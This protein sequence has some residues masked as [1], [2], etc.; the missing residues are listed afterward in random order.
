M[1]SIAPTPVRPCAA[2]TLASSSSSETYQPFH[3]QTPSMSGRSRQERSLGAFTSAVPRTRRLRIGSSS[4]IAGPWAQSTGSCTTGCKRTGLSSCGWTGRSCCRHEP[5]PSSAT[6]T[7]WW[8]L[9]GAANMVA[10]LT[11][12]PAQPLSHSQLEAK[13]GAGGSTEERSACAILRVNPWLAYGCGEGARLWL[14]KPGAAESTACTVQ[15]ILRDD[16]VRRQFG[17]HLLHSH[18][19]GSGAPTTAILRA[20]TSTIPPLAS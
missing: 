2:S 12:L 8:C 4:R 15:R 6:I 18:Q 5:V 1:A 9:R 11:R 17:S 19:R 7:L 3:R 16:S 20:L 13:L 10:L 14:R